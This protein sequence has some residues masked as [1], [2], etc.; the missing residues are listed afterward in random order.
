MNLILKNSKNYNKTIITLKNIKKFIHDVPLLSQHNLFKK[1]GI[2]GLY[3]LQGYQTAWIDYQRYLCM[4]LTLY[5]NGTPN[6][7]KTPYHILLNTAKPSIYQH[8]FHFASQTHNNHFFFE[9]INHKSNAQKTTPSN[10]LKS[11]LI[12]LNFSSIDD[13]KKK[14]LKLSE[15]CYGQ[16]WIFL[17]EK[18]DKT[19]ELMLCNNDGTPYYYLKNQQMDLN[20]G[21]DRK[22]NKHMNDLK[23]RI[24]NDD[25]D[26]FTLPI[27]G[28]SLW[29]HSY[30]SDYGVTGKETFLH[31]L[32]D[33]IDW[34]IINK[35]LFVI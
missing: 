23:L 6:E 15:K 29:T 25:D 10:V 26:D 32:W 16:G 8:V 30:I 1:N 7:Y 2:E 17:V 20:H 24:K 18:K 4:K 11:K 28:I 5:T 35:R 34:N 31:K 22:T 27:L 21:F 19:L 33:C 14:I 12:S 9:Q 3:S 13:L